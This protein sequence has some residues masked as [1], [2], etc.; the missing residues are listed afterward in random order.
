MPDTMPCSPQEG[1][2]AGQQEQV[3]V[4]RLF[5]VIIHI[6]QAGQPLWSIKPDFPGFPEV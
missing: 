2:W 3:A 5:G 1:T 4:A 6:H